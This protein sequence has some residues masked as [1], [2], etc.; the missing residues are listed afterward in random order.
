VNRWVIRVL[1]F[2]LLIVLPAALDVSRAAP[3]I[4]ADINATVIHLLAGQGV[5]YRETRSFSGGSLTSLLFGLPGCAEPLQVIPTNH[6][7]EA[8]RLFDKVSEPGDV[9]LFAYLGKVSKEERDEWTFVEHLKYRFL[10]L[11]LLS[12]YQVDGVMLMI[13]TPKD[14]DAPRINWSLAWNAEYRRSIVPLAS[15]ST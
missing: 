6:A 8:R 2:G 1:L 9:R 10:E 11:F 15:P 5:P 3:T 13:V 14:C 4:G 12:P 7:F